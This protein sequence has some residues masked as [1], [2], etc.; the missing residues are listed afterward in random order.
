MFME[1]KAAVETK[2]EELKQTMELIE[3]KCTYYKTALEAGK[4]DIHKD[5][6][7]GEPFSPKSVLN[8]LDNKLYCL[9]FNPFVTIIEYNKYSFIC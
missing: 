9:M 7:M 2:M 4:E 5:N 1:R 8:C 3:H 6:K